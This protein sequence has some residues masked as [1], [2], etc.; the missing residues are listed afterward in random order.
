M[1]QSNTLDVGI[2]MDNIKIGDT[3][4]IMDNGFSFSSYTN[5]VDA[6]FRSEFRYEHTVQNGMVGV[7]VQI[8]PHKS[9][10]RSYSNLLGVRIDG[11]IYIIEDKGVEIIS[12]PTTE[13]PSYQVG[14]EVL[15]VCDDYAY[16]YYWEWLNGEL[17][18]YATRG[19]YPAEG[20]TGEVVQVGEHLKT[21][22][23]LLGVRIDGKIFIIEY[24]GVEL[25]TEEQEPRGYKL[26]DMVRIINGTENFQ[27]YSEWLDA[28]FQTAFV[29]GT[30]MRDG[31]IGTVVQVGPHKG[32]EAAQYGGSLLGVRF[33][34][35]IFVYEDIDVEKAV[36][37]ECQTVPES[38]PPAGISVKFTPIIN[39]ALLSLLEK[40]GDQAT[41]ARNAN[42]NVMADMYVGMVDEVHTALAHIA[43]LK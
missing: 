40:L 7:V 23:P 26:G 12:P 1:L 20:S 41:H 3:V 8:G 10:P 5:W 19:E 16:A 24:E 38:T 11:I 42:H 21:S 22:V 14:D 27:Y 18:D 31:D 28:E 43:G 32:I 37:A 33:A 2:K 9:D 39:V 13:S 15:I 25:T 29:G 36:A 30:S 4:R 35:Q 6:E 17:Q 34:N